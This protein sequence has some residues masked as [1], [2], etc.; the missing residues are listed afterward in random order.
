VA[1]VV[2]FGKKQFAVGGEWKEASEDIGEVIDGAKEV[3]GGFYHVISAGKKKSDAGCV[4]SF[5]FEE[6]VKAPVFSLA[7]LVASVGADGIYVIPMPDARLWYVSIREGMVVTGT[8]RVDDAESALN[9]I[10]TIVTISER[11]GEERKVFAPI[12]IRRPGWSVIEVKELL[13]RGK[14][15][16]LVAN[17][18]ASPAVAIA[19][20]V[21][22][23]AVAGAL[24]WWFFFKGPS[25]AE[26]AAEQAE[27]ARQ[28]YV[29]MIQQ[30]V[31]NLPSDH[32][33]VNRAYARVMQAAPAFVAGYALKQARCVPGSCTMSYEVAPDAPFAPDVIRQTLGSGVTVDLTGRAAAF[34]I[35]V[36]TPMVLVDDP[37]IRS[38]P[39]SKNETLARIGMLPVYAPNLAIER[40]PVE[41]DLSAAAG[42]LPPGYSPIVRTVVPLRVREPD[43]LMPA[44]VAAL[45]DFWANSGFVPT[46]LTWT[47]GFGEAPR[48]SAEF[49]RVSGVQ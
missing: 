45:A 19:A 21:G 2:P 3:D 44:D 31:A 28:A 8:D 49:T 43:F 10:S 41:E 14:V 7:A 15:K 20:V 46:S 5:T 12:E 30:Q 25:E 22:V 16:P 37:L 39:V 32:A 9:A 24:G 36:D 40:D 47:F 18:E 23:F 11:S 42:S 34:T 17:T 6:K 29:A 35:Q 13:S 38:W 1:I 27:A 4:G 33:W 48:W 26:K